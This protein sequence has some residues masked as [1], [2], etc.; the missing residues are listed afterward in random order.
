M[1]IS[2]CFWSSSWTQCW[3]GAAPCCIR[4]WPTTGRRRRPATRGCGWRS[5]RL[6]PL[7]DVSAVRW[8]ERLCRPGGAWT[9]ARGENPG[10]RHRGGARTC[11]D[12]RGRRPDRRAQTSRRGS[13]KGLAPFWRRAQ[14]EFPGQSGQG[15]LV[16]LR[17]RRGRRHH[18]L[19]HAHRGAQLRRGDRAPGRE[20][21][22]GVALRGGHQRPA[23]AGGQRTRLLQANAAAAAFF[24]DALQS[25]EAQIGRDFPDGSGLRRRGGRALRGRLRAALLG[26]PDGPPTP[27]RLQRCGVAGRRAG[28]T[29]RP[30]GL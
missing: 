16:L 3:R 11:P 8:H 4:G 6:P 17:L 28:G 14:P 5:T 20:V 13:L 15:A 12:R 18:R 30:R 1:Q 23:P 21:P 26:R 25:A 29:A 24:V 9:P 2:G 7:T 22:G 19:R 10:R 27:R